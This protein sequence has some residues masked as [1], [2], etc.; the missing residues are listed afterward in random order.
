M[1]TSLA[2]IFCITILS[3]MAC[4]PR[5]PCLILLVLLGFGF[6]VFWSLLLDEDYYRSYARCDS[7]H[8]IKTSPTERCPVEQTPFLD[9]STDTTKLLEFQR[10]FNY[11]NLTC[12]PFD[13]SPCRTSPMQSYVGEEEKDSAVCAIKYQYSNNSP[14]SCPSTYTIRTYSSL[15]ASYFDDLST[16]T[17]MGACG[18]CSSTQDLAVLI[19][20]PDMVT[21]SLQCIKSG[22]MVRS[23]NSHECFR[24]M[25]FSE[26][27]AF[28]WHEYARATM[29]DCFIQCLTADVGDKEFNNQ[30]N[31]E[32]N[33]CLQ[34]QKEKTQAI[35]ERV[36]GRTYARSGLL[37]SVVQPCDEIPMLEHDACPSA[38]S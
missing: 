2:G 1:H 19:R 7:C 4:Y 22:G 20:I 25:G 16:V 11:Y 12:N 32:L 23:E 36:A 9:Y 21:A 28:L 8:C 3:T 33:K 24:N 38:L 31:C 14:D 37:S 27:C 35:F 17:H 34:C 15:Q 26:P 30:E 10:P 18:V 29:R 6:V 5:L 13:T